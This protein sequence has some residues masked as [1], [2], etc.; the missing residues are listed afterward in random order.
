V[1]VFVGEKLRALGIVKEGQ[2]WMERIIF[3]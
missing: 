3:A 1:A 2:V